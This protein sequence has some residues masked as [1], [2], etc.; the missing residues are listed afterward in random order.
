MLLD[1]VKDTW[2]QL[3]AKASGP[4]LS[5]D[6]N[7]R[8]DAIMLRVAVTRAAMANARRLKFYGPEYQQAVLDETARLLGLPISTTDVHELGFPSD[9]SLMKNVNVSWPS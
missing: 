4:V 9:P 5:R 1:A 7:D 6:P 2:W 3:R 8:R